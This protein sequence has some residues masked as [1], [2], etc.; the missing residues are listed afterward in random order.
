ML[1]GTNLTRRA[2]RDPTIVL[3]V[4]HQKEV[5]RSRFV[6][7]DHYSCAIFCFDIHA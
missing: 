1:F 2:P 7:G 3:V 6:A 4:V 5:A